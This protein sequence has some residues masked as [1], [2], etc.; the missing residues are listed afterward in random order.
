MWSRRQWIYLFIPQGLVSCSLCTQVLLDPEHSAMSPTKPLASWGCLLQGGYS[1]CVNKWVRIYIIQRRKAW[2]IKIKQKGVMG[3][4]SGQQGVMMSSRVAKEGL[5]G[6]VALEEE[7]G[8]GEPVGCAGSWLGAKGTMGSQPWGR[9]LPLR[10]EETR[11]ANEAGRTAEADVLD[12][13][14]QSVQDLTTGHCETP[15]CPLMTGEAI[16]G[17]WAQEW[18][19]QSG[20]H[21]RSRLKRG[22][23]IGSREIMKE[24]ILQGWGDG[25]LGQG[26]SSGD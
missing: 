15:A 1:D 17:Y 16:E 19:G 26:G 2:R 13:M 21:V 8:G 14:G 6:E 4:R 3:A 18:P 12:I 11:W 25:A 7:P 20:C 9:C 10:M 5:S 23:R 24:L 22:D